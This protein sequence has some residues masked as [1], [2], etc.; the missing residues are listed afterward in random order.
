MTSTAAATTASPKVFTA[1]HAKLLEASAVPVEHATAAGARTYSGIASLP[2]T[3][4]WAGEYGPGILFE[5]VGPTGSRVYQARPDAVPEGVGK[6]LQEAGKQAISIHPSRAHLV[7]HAASVMIV[8]GTKQS[9]SASFYAPADCLTV[10]IQGAYGWSHDGT[11]LQEM[12]LSVLGAGA[13]VTLAFD[14]DVAT[15]PDVWRAAD[16]LA[17]VMRLDGA[18]SVGFISIPGGGKIGLDDFLASRPEASRAGV[19]ATMIASAKPKLPRRPAARK[20]STA[21]I[22]TPIVDIEAGSI[23]RPINGEGGVVVGREVLLDASIR[24][25]RT[26]SVWDDLNDV[27]REKVDISHDVEVSFASP[28][29][30]EVTR[31][32]AVGVPD[33]ELANAR[34]VLNRAGAEATAIAPNADI[35]NVDRLIE[36]AIRAHEPEARKFANEI[37]RTGWVH[38]G[39]DWVFAHVGG[40]ISRVRDDDARTRAAVS[41]RL[42]PVDFGRAESR[43]T[44]AG[45]DAYGAIDGFAELWRSFKNPTVAAMLIGHAMSAFSGMKPGGS[46]SLI[47]AHGSGKSTALMADMALLAPEFAD[48]ALFSISSTGNAIGE[49]GR[50]A[51]NLPFAI[52]DFHYL[53]S[54]DRFR[55][56]SDALDLAIRVGYGEPRKS[57][58]TAGDAGITENPAERSAPALLYAGEIAVTAPSALERTISVQFTL[59]EEL[60]DDNARL[61]AEVA[62]AGAP[63]YIAARFIEWVAGIVEMGEYLRPDEWIYPGE[64]PDWP[65]GDWGRWQAL[66]SGI[67]ARELE[68]MRQFTDFAE[69]SPRTQGVAA[70][71]ATG[72]RLFEWFERVSIGDEPGRGLSRLRLSGWRG[73]IAA[74]AVKHSARYLDH[75]EPVDSAL[76]SLRAMLATHSA[77]LVGHSEWPGAA[78]HAI[79]IGTYTT[80]TT[81]PDGAQVDCFSIITAA[82]VKALSVYDQRGGWTASKLKN[83]LSDIVL[84]APNRAVERHIRL[85]GTKVAVLMIPKAT[86]MGEDELEAA[87]AAAGTLATELPWTAGRPTWDAL[88][89]AAAAG[90]TGQGAA[91]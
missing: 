85:S 39:G 20:R 46:P 91:V 24:I 80:T 27:K 58:L 67:K 13:A 28:G 12:S 2:K 61:M 55:E 51:E 9:L 49:A 23:Y 33:R 62:A 19:L 40:A 25:L 87:P 70:H 41:E 3:I 7:G 14:G 44:E 21:T 22:S 83:A 32:V 48:R 81:G 4:S 71:L 42:Q 26:V 15:N 56:L 34:L 76:G 90:L 6:Y 79:E 63:Q 82:A 50:G 37:K 74:A 53:K 89:R 60:T 65:R 36:S 59:G 84:R 31:V 38:V 16:R 66:L 64:E 45:G 30:E 8:E 88:D 73:L 86:W 47:G 54:P 68:A 17:E 35:R 11:P 77:E 57:R 5:H 18:A 1:A 72:V 10:G 69:L 75:S 78:G 52:D 29:A 43:I